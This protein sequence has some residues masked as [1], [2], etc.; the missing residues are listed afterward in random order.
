MHKVVFL[1]VILLCSSIS[2]QS[3]G[4]FI[5][6]AGEKDSIP[7]TAVTQTSNE[8][9]FQFAIVSDR[10]GGMRKGIFKLAIDKL[11]LLQPEFVM[12]VGDLVDGYTE[13]EELA[14]QEWDELD[15]IIAGLNA[16]FF[17]LPGN[18][19]FT[20]PVMKDIWQKRRGRSYYHFLYKNCLF[21]CLNTEEDQFNGISDQQAAYFRK[22][23]EQ[24]RDVNWT[25]VF[26]HKP[27]WDYQDQHGY[28]EIAELLAGRH[29]TL[30]SGHLHNYVKKERNGNGHF[31]LATT[32]GVSNL[33]G[34]EFGEFDHIVWV[35]AS[36]DHP[37]ITNLALDGIYD[38]NVVI[39]KDYPLVE[40]LR[41]GNWFKADPVVAETDN[42]KELQTNLIFSNP[43]EQTLE[44]TGKLES[45]QNIQFVPRD[46]KLS[47]PAKSEHSIPLILK[48]SNDNVR[49][50]KLDPVNLSLN[51][52]FTDSRNR[53]LKL[54]ATQA[55]LMDWK[56]KCS[57]SQSKI[58]VDGKLNEWSGSQWITAE[59]PQ[60]FN[61]SWDWHGTDDGLF[62]IGT[63]FDDQYLYFALNASD[64]RVF[65]EQVDSSKPRD[66]F[67]LFLE[68]EELN[69][70]LT[71][72]EISPLKSG[73][74]EIQFI[75]GQATPGMKTAC[76]TDENSITLECAI[77]IKMS[78][79][80]G[81]QFRMNAAFEDH[82][83]PNNT[84]P[85]VL[86]WRPK[87]NTGKDYKDSGL[88][89]LQ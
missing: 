4:Q 72:I 79:P 59:H 62:R 55:L 43:T 12:C 22:A 80:E 64:D 60:D 33:R 8:E 39:E 31:V 27:Y 49:I 57:R 15:A 86:F 65:I 18:H 84:K 78:N 76:V 47:I 51:G 10:T 38:E 73:K 25:F 81:K 24:N 35:T 26:M 28:G 74:C 36:K 23:L 85:S 87:W 30:F 16:P 88:F 19:D 9:N 66:R 56:H 75:T 70:P 54:P 68:S 71:A 82:D 5:F 50:S 14:R 37:V 7:W 11:N 45:Q 1:F 67:T 2:A 53:E 77:P 20:N 3:N 40:T 69:I 17:Y 48:A 44:V 32:G 83:N 61:E 58:K 42:I 29:F 52:S 89:I 13:N 46:L 34:A 6:S 21:L 63:T 41:N